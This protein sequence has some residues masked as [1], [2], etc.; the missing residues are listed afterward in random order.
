MSL[1]DARPPASPSVRWLR[2]L[3]LG[4]VLAYALLA[5]LKSTPEV[6][7]MPGMPRALGAWL[8]VHDFAKN[9]AGFA[10]LTLAAHVAFPERLMRNAL[11]VGALAAA[12]EAVQYFMPHRFADV[13]DVVAGLGGAALASAAWWL[14][15]KIAEP[16]HA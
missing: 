6:R 12:I 11:A 9:V 4:A 2:L 7:F 5:G 3:P 13:R 15:R 14:G 8:D 16:R 10:A 1:P